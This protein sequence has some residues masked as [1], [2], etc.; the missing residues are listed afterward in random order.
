MVVKHWATRFVVLFLDPICFVSLYWYVVTTPLLL[1]FSGFFWVGSSLPVPITRCPFD[2]GLLVF[3]E[4]D[5]L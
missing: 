2:V 3:E 5:L 4:E 1:F